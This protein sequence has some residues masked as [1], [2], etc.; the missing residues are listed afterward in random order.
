MAAAGQSSR[1]N[2]PV[3]AAGLASVMA[4]VALCLRDCLGLGH[5]VL[6]LGERQLEVDSRGRQEAFTAVVFP[7]SS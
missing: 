1:R 7:H 3:W 6:V 2:I 4:E 5:R